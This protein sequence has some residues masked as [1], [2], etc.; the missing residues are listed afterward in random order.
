MGRKGE[1]ASKF[2]N[3]DRH[4]FAWC[5]AEHFTLLRNRAEAGT[6]RLKTHYQYLTVK[7]VS[8]DTSVS[9]SLLRSRVS[10]TSPDIGDAGTTSGSTSVDWTPASTCSTEPV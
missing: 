2:V 8:D 1:R 10:R 9:N 5:Y 6:D 7:W 4:W 3:V